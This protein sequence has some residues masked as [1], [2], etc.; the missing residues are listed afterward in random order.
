MKVMVTGANGQLGHDLVYLL[1]QQPVQLYSFTKS[2]LDITNQ[3]AVNHMVQKI[4]PNVIINAAAFTKVDL[5]E[6]NEE[7][8]FSI[9][10]FGQRNLSVAAEKHGAKICY[11]STDYV[12]DGTGSTPY[13]EYDITNPVGIYGKSKLAGEE[14]TKSMCSRY[15][16]VRTAWV[17]GKYGNN[18]VHTMIRLG[19][20]REQLGVVN[21]Q[22]GSPTYTVDLARFIIDL[23]KTEK[24]GIYHA[25]NNG[26][27]SWYEFAQAIFEESEIEIKVTPLTTD[28]YPTAAKRPS[29]SVLDNLSIRVNGF[30]QL[31]PWRD[32]LKEFLST[33][34]KKQE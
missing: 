33:N 1:E 27:C 28:Q 31:R 9:N 19:N 26:S 18:F 32:A 25:T 29:Y 8:A 34:Y 20:E 10:T 7:T 5:A 14:V 6:S 21:D 4:R 24:Y 15:F 2:E 11:I 30:E 16:I 17:Y 12:F 13:N 3:S 23:I 22:K